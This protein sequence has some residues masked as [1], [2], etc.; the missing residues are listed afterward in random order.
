MSIKGNEKKKNIKIMHTP[1][2][3]VYYY[4]FNIY[5]IITLT[6]ILCRQFVIIKGHDNMNILKVKSNEFLKI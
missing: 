5:I 3:V 4:L 2:N 1:L 6:R